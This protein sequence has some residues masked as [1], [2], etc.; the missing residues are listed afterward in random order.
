M[1]RLPQPLYLAGVLALALLLIVSAPALASDAKGT[2]LTVDANNHT[3]ELTTADGNVLSFRAYIT[4]DVR[5][6]DDPQSMWELQAGDEIAVTY[7]VDNGELVATEIR[8]ARA[9]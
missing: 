3:F 1:K 5:I 7:E 6:N 2:I 8:C 4:V 9:E